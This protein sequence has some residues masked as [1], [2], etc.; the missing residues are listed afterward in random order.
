VPQTTTLTN[1]DAN[2]AAFDQFRQP[3]P[4]IAEKLLKAFSKNNDPILSIGCGTGQYESIFSKKL[5]IIGLDRSMGMIGKAKDRIQNV[6]LG[7][8]TSLPFAEHQFSGA[9]FMQS[10]HHVGAN[11]TISQNNRDLARKRALKEAIRVIHHGPIFIVQRDP[12]QNQAVWFWKY[13]PR[14]LEVKLIIQPKIEMYVEWFGCFGLKDVT[15]EA[16]QDPMIQGFFDP[17]APLD[18]EF[19]RSFSDCKLRFA[20]IGGTVFVVSGN[21]I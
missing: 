5:P 9:Y 8:M 3:N 16:I 2:A 1:Y 18:P 11:L 19:R 20:E 17:R 7:D 10:L 6:S 14:A 4:V 13:F 12:S 21:K 15:A